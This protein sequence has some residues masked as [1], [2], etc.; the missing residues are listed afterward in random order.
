MEN[1]SR[2]ATAISSTSIAECTF[3]TS[4]RVQAQDYHREALH[5]RNFAPM[6]IGSTTFIG[7]FG[8]GMVHGSSEVTT[9]SFVRKSQSRQW[10]KKGWGYPMTLSVA[11]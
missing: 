6:Y 7:I 4:S 2:R 3:R 9:P 8:N 11:L 10:R 1:T 5:T